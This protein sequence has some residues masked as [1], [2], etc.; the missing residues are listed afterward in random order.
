[1]LRHTGKIRY[2]SKKSFMKPFHTKRYM[3]KLFH[4]SKL[5][6]QKLENISVYRYIYVKIYLCIDISTCKYISLYRYICLLYLSNSQSV[7]T[8][9]ISDI[10]SS[11]VANNW[12]W[13]SFPFS[14]C[15]RVKPFKNS[16]TKIVPTITKIHIIKIIK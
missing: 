5:F 14:N 7:K 3:K 16:K 4:T 8:I 13:L 11:C 6:V 10:R 2:K 1:M 9:S 12:R 15:S